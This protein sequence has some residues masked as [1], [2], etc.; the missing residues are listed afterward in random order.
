M[1]CFAVRETA[2]CVQAKAPATSTQNTSPWETCP[3]QSKESGQLDWNRP[4]L[5]EA[6]S[7]GS[8][9]PPRAAATAPG[10]LQPPHGHFHHK[11]LPCIACMRAAAAAAIG[12]AVMRLL[13]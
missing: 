3:V 8:R 4:H 2:A 9:Q 10:L 5:G 12:I 7:V 6:W 1:P 13:G 11:A